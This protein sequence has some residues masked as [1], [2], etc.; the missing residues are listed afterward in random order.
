MD[1]QEN[2]QHLRTLCQRLTELE[3]QVHRLQSALQSACL[4]DN[5]DDISWFQRELDLAYEQ[6]RMI[7]STYQ[8]LQSAA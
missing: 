2:V 7:H 6:Y 4:D 1:S 5:D 8:A 3:R